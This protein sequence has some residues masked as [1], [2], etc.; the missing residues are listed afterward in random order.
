MSKKLVASDLHKVS[1]VRP[2]ADEVR[3]FLV[4]DVTVR[5]GIH[6]LLWR[7]SHGFCVLERNLFV[8]E[9][10]IFEAIVLSDI[11]VVWDV[12]TRWEAITC[13]RDDVQAGEIWVKHLFLVKCWLPRHVWDDIFAVFDQGRVGLTLFLIVD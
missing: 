11:V 5:T 2:L 13:E 6:L 9:Y 1:E 4:F 7:H 3:F 10:D 12:D 8:L